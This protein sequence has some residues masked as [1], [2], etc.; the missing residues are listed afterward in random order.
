[1]TRRALSFGAAASV[2]ER[3]RPGYP[4]EL[5]DQVLDYAG[6]PVT[7]AL[8]IGAGTGKATRAFAARG[9]EVPPPNQTQRCWQSFASTYRH[10]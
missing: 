2:Y 6:Q 8:E 9:I 3:F 4:D 5:A 10:Q 7:S 1:M